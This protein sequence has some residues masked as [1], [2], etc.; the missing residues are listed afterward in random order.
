[1]AGLKI[2]VME[3]ALHK[4]IW[5]SLGATTPMP[6]PIYTELEQGVIDGQENPIWVIDVYKFYEIQKHMTMTRHDY[7]GHIDVAP[8]KW[9]K[10]LSPP[11]QELIQ[12][13]MIEAAVYQ[14]KDN[15]DRDAERL[16][17][18]KTK[19]MQ[20]ETAPDIAGFRAKVEKLKDMEL[21]QEPRVKAFLMKVMEATR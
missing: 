7:S 5:Q 20:I 12:K 3:S 1:V 18:L 9:W 19:G 10:T 8:L 17:M 16:A 21:F 15:R 14:R 4:A 2:R 6:W 13:A 11:Q